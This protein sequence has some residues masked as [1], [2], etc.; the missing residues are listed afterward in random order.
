MLVVCLLGFAA[1]GFYAG[2]FVGYYFGYCSGLDYG[3][4]GLEDYH[5]FVMKKLEQGWWTKE[6][7]LVKRC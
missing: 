4:K 5:E 2:Y 7:D 6:G 1:I 3:K